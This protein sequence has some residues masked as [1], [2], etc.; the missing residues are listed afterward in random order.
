MKIE[1]AVKII[2]VLLVIIILTLGAAIIL[3]DKVP[4][5]NENNETEITDPSQTTGSENDQTSVPPDT[6]NPDTSVPDTSEPDTSVPDTSV[7]DTS[8]P[9]DY[10]SDFV[11]NRSF[12]SDSGTRLN[13]RAEVSAVMGEDGKI[14][15]KVDLYLDHSSLY[16]NVR[17]SNKISLSS[18]ETVFKSEKI[19][20]GENAKH[21]TFLQSIENTYEYGDTVDLYALFNA[22]CT[23]GGVRVETLEIEE[24]FVLEAE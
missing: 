17:S 5:E 10:P 1:V 24:S 8:E 6:S 20:Y 11:M 22:K 12:T 14:N 18:K 19:E 15:V 21:S 3:M 4:S 2:I 13:I 16:I 9:D 23:Y 7:P